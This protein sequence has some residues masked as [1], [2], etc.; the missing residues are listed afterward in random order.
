M[1]YFCAALFLEARPFIERYQLQKTSALKNMQ[2]FQGPAASLIISGAGP[3]R[4][5]AAVAHLLTLISPEHCPGNNLGHLF[6]NVGLAGSIVFPQGEIVLCHKLTNT[7]TGYDFYPEIPFG[8]G[9]REGAL[10]SFGHS[11]RAESLPYDLADME[12]AFVFEAAEFFL[13]LH[14][15]VCLKVVSDQFA[16]RDVS[17]E[18]AAAVMRRAAD[19]IAA[20]IDRETA[21]LDGAANRFFFSPEELEAMERVRQNLFLTRAMCLA[22]EKACQKAKSREENILSVLAEAAGSGRGGKNAS[23]PIYARLMRQLS[24]TQK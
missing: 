20:W 6:V 3:T 21:R 4:A 19:P 1:I 12:G 14:Q 24:P 13:P 11:I 7:F 18:T 23:K 17:A 16:P 5:A 8:H 2:I 22:L 15:I 10:G 9:F